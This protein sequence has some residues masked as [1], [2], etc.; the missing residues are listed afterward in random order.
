MDSSRRGPEAGAPPPS[1][2]SV[3][4]WRGDP[5]Y[6]ATRRRMVWNERLPDRYPDVIVTVASDADVVAAVNL[7]R[8]RGLRVAVRAGGHSWIGTSLRDGGLLIDLSRL[9]GVTVDAAARQAAAQ[10]AI[11]NTE[12]VAALAPHGLAFPAGHCPT[13]AIGGYLLA[14]GQG[15]N[16]GGWGIACQNV[17][18]IDLVNADGDVITADAQHHPDLLWAARGGG[19]GFPGVILRYHL[20]LF[21]PP[22][23]I[24]QSLYVYPLELI[25]EVAAW[26]AQTVPSLPSSVEQLLLLALPPLA[27]AA[28]LGGPPQRYLTLWPVAY[29]DSAAETAAALAPLE[30]C[31]VLDRALVR[32]VNTPVTWDDL[33]AIEAA[34]FP[35]GHRYDVGIIWSDADPTTVLRGLRDRLAQAPSLKTEILVAVTGPPTVDPAARE[36][37]YSMAGP[38]YV[39]VY[40]VWDDPAADETNERWHHETL[41]SL[42]PVTRGHYMGETDLLASPRRAAEALA[43][44][45]WER[46]QAIRQRYDPQG[47]FWGHIG[48]A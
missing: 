17:V 13:V 48:Q 36:M 23:V 22:R 18:A 37:A 3:T 2:A 33:F 41:A 26:L 12:L 16:Q 19:P 35:E 5:A 14:G 43:P 38:L 31:P 34:T 30:T 28:Q 6:E 25:E 39:G 44:G 45:V 7:A 32:Q 21:P 40:S 42:A 47:V 1:G 10:P 29:G 8:G 9:N 20:R 11:K 4:V 27:A 46:L 24:M 15:W